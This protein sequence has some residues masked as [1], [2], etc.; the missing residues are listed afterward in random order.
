[1]NE[2]DQVLKRRKEVLK[3]SRIIFKKSIL[4]FISVIGIFTIFV[5]GTGYIITHVLIHLFR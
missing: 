2:Y 3:N 4:F 1:M 5:I